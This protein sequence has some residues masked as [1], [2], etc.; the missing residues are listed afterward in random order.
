MVGIESVR[1]GRWTTHCEGTA[2][3]SASL[4]QNGSTT[5]NGDAQKLNGNC[6]HSTSTLNR[7]TP[8]DSDPYQLHPLTIY[9]CLQHALASAAST[10]QHGQGCDGGGDLKPGSKVGLKIAAVE[11]FRVWSSE[12]RTFGGDWTVHAAN[13]DVKLE[14]QVACVDLG[15]KDET[16]AVASTLL[17]VHVTGCEGEVYE[18]FDTDLPPPEP[19]ARV[20]TFLRPLLE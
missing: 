16:G 19:N 15:L 12:K 6:S 9:G 4:H 5:Q 7:I 8:K 10:R 18:A 13:R 1:D 14:D 2:A 20:P 17:G 11:E 3:V